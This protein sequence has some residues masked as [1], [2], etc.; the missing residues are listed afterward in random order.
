MGPS[1]ISPTRSSAARPA[2]SMKCGCH[3]NC[4]MG[5]VLFVNKRT[6]EMIT[7]SAFLDLEQLLVDIQVVT[8][9]GAQPRGP[10]RWPRRRSRSSRTSSP[11][12]SAAQV[13]IHVDLVKQFSVEPATAASASASSKTTR[14]SSVNASRRR[15][16]VP[17]SLQLRPPHRDVHHP[18]RHAA[19]RDKLLRVQHRRRLA[20]RDR[21]DEAQRLGRRWYRTKGRRMVYA[22]NKTC[23]SPIR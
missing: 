8:D 23:R 2:G 14:K 4:G 7:L 6:K 15:H 16:V 9:A 5:A 22:K 17:G 12:A 18:V 13:R 10:S 19:R 21:E 3:P 11:E 1:A 20:E